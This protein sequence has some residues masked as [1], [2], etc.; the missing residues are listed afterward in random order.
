MSLIC[1]NWTP[2]YYTDSKK[3]TLQHRHLLCYRLT[4]DMPA[5]DVVPYSYNNCLK[6]KIGNEKKQ[7]VQREAPIIIIIIILQVQIIALFLILSLVLSNSVSH[8]NMWERTSNDCNRIF[9]LTLYNKISRTVYMLHLVH[10]IMHHK[11]CGRG[12][13]TEL[14]IWRSGDRALW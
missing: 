14:N 8:S 2:S 4:A 6:T 3:T 13:D 5:P 7:W 11:H 12:S 1:L 10:F 9:C